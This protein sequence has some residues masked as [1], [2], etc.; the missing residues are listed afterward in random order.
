MIQ[1][2]AL[3]LDAYRELNAKKLFWIT[4][5]L[6][7]VVMILFALVGINGPNITLTGLHFNVSPLDPFTVYKMVFS[8]IVI[9]IWLSWAA[10]VLA[11]ISTA[12]LFP[13]LISGGTIDLYL[14]KPISRLRL[15]LTKYATGLLFV[16]LQ[17]S[18]FALG[19]FLV[20]GLRATSGTQ[21]CFLQF[22]WLSACSATCSHFAFCLEFGRGPPLLPFFSRSY[23]GLGSSEFKRRMP[24]C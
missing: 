6:S 5:S 20:F 24:H 17:V 22:P 10:V 21:A 4:L 7:G 2:L 23:S 8:L 11:L 19:S 18:V 14:S 15:F 12:G 13:D 9:G 1:T 16:T 3:F